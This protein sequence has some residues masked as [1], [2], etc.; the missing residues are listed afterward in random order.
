MPVV[1]EAVPSRVHAVEPVRRSDP[2]RPAAVLVDGPDAIGAQAGRIARLVQ[3]VLEAVPVVPVQP[4]RGR[5]PQEAVVVLRDAP[6][7]AP[8]RIVDGEL[9]EADVPPIDDGKTDDLVAG[10]GRGSGAILRGRIGG[11]EYRRANTSAAPVLRDGPAIAM[12]GEEKSQAL[13]WSDAEDVRAVARMLNGPSS[14]FRRESYGISGP[15]PGC[16]GNGVLSIPSGVAWRP[17]VQTRIQRL[18]HCQPPPRL[19]SSSDQRE[20]SVQ[21]RLNER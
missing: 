15:A 7:P 4:A 19:L 8:R 9:E 10:R 1:R 13:P 12:S 11:R 5:Q 16:R 17:S 14:V 2:E 3:V 6:D 18:T 21:L 20:L